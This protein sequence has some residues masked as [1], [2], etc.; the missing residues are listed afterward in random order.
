[1]GA[2]VA[3]LFTT[4]LIVVLALL[5]PGE[6]TLAQ[7]SDVPARTVTVFAA[8]SL[9][10]A[11][12]AVGKSYAASGGKLI[13]SYAAS[14]AL[15]KQIEQGAPADIFISSDLDWMDYL[16]SNGLIR[17]ETRADLLGNSLVLVAPA[18]STVDLSIAPGFKLLD[19]LG[20]EGRLAVADP[21]SVPAGK[22]ARQALEHLGVWGAVEPRLVPTENVRAALALVAL[23]EVP[24]GIVYRTDA[25]ADPKVKVVGTFPADSHKPIIYPIAAVEKS[26]NS[27][28]AD[29]FLAFLKTAPAA[30]IF[31]EQGFTVAH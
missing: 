27:A 22:Y 8:A 17:S 21:A 13:A 28:E 3:R 7:T 6:R 24:L 15:A 11:L 1:M 26:A 31:R 10:N 14:S 9:K 25:L 16:A 5:A 4:V 12:D 2:N 23:G 29:R 20:A 19:A 18:A 30:T